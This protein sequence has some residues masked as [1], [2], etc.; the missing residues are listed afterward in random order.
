[1]ALSLLGRV[2][3]TSEVFHVVPRESVKLLEC[4]DFVRPCEGHPGA[5]V[6]A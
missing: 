6:E 3:H 5:A 2:R 4:S 1:M